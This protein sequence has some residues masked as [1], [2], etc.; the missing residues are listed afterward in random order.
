M[1]II[2]SRKLFFRILERLN[3]NPTIQTFYLVYS[4]YIQLYLYSTV[5]IKKISDP[6][7]R[8]CSEAVASP[9]PVRLVAAAGE[10]AQRT[11]VTASAVGHPLSAKVS[12]SG[13]TPTVV[14]PTHGSRSSRG[15]C[16]PR[17]PSRQS[18]QTSADPAGTILARIVA[19]SLGSVFE[20]D[21]IR[22]SCLRIV[23]VVH[24]AV[25]H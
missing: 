20:F 8:C 14:R 7:D 2:L 16:G 11:I 17:V 4:F 18:G 19:W 24:D 1:Q 6:L 15:F 5:G 9:R 21:R 3:T 13:D 10:S 25:R 23:N 12:A 22:V